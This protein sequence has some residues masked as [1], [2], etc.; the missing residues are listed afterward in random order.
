MERPP[1]RAPPRSC[2]RWGGREVLSVSGLVGLDDA[3]RDPAPVAHRVP[4]LARPVA[5]R[6]GLLAVHPATTPRG[7]RPATA[8]GAAAGAADLPGG[9]DKARECV[10]QLPGVLVGQVDLVVGAVQ[11]KADGLVRGYV[12]VE[13][14]AQDYLN[15]A[16]HSVLFSTG[17]RV[18][19][20]SRVVGVRTYSTMRQRE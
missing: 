3:G 15:L 4:V 19:F 10:A 17:T 2:E 20:C 11:G 8:R 6:T 1:C 16:R 18:T 14:V 5:D 9:L 13:I 7:T 12:L